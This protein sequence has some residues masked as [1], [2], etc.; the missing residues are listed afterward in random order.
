LADAWGP[1]AADRLAK[2]RANHMAYARVHGEGA[3]AAQEKFCAVISRLY[4]RDSLGGVRQIA[5][6]P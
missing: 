6:V 3:Y 4:E 5:R 1:Y 2:W